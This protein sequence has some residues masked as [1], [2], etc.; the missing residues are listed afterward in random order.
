[1]LKQITL[2]TIFIVGLLVLMASAVLAYGQGIHVEPEMAGPGDTVTVS[3]EDFEANSTIKITLHG[4]DGVLK[5][6]RTD[7]AGMF[8]ADVVIPAGMP[9]GVHMLMARDETGEMSQFRLTVDASSSSGSSLS[10]LVYIIGGISIVV[11]VA[12]IMGLFLTRKPRQ[13]AIVS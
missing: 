2:T 10:T 4:H 1:M 3:G 6:A 8:S 5:V 11:L 9:D 7:A 12:G 13:A